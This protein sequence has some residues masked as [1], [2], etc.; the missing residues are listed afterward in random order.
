[1]TL[2]PNAEWL[3]HGEPSHRW[4]HDKPEYPAIP[5]R[6]M[7]VMPVARQLGTAFLSCLKHKGAV[8]FSGVPF[9]KNK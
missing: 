7:D 6:S 2:R 8:S 5:T 9:T 4:T 1:M 3:A